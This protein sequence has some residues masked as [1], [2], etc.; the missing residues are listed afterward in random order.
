MASTYSKTTTTQNTS[1]KGGSTSKTSATGK[2]SANTEQKRNQALND[3]KESSQVQNAYN[4]LQNT[5]NNKPG[6]FTSS[7]QDQ[8]NEIYNRIMNREEFNFNMNENSLYQQLKNQ[9]SVLGKQAM[10]DTMGQAAAMTGGY[11]SSYA[12]TAGQQTYQNYLQELNSQ[13][14]DL[15]SMELQRYQQEGEN[16]QNQY[17][18]SRDMYDTEYGQYRDSVSDWQADRDYYSGLYQDERNFDYGKYSDNRTFWND[19][20]WNERNA[21]QTTESSSW[22]NTSSTQTSTTNSSTSSGGSGG[23]SSRSKSSSKSG[24]SSG[25]SGSSG[26]TGNKLVLTNAAS[27]AAIQN[28]VKILSQQPKAFAQ[29]QVKNAYDNGN[30]SQSMLNYYYDQ[31]GW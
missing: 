9:Y 28:N 27:N 11:G 8:L 18:L 20:Y 30:I 10:Q 16:M 26:S 24:G 12:Q 22:E 19:E 14:P 31:L 15:Y 23:S 29:A 6:A 4:Q 25:S 17:A 3:Y 13:L 5:L 7:Y 21:E 2:V 1:T